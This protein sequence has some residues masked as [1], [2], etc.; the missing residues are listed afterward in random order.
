MAMQSPA[1]QANAQP[2]IVAGTLDTKTQIRA[3]FR[4]FARRT[5][6]LAGM[7]D[8]EIDEA[9][10]HHIEM[11]ENALEQG[12]TLEEAIESASS[13]FQHTIKDGHLKSVAPSTVV[14]TAILTNLTRAHYQDNTYTT[15]EGDLRYDPYEALVQRTAYENMIKIA[16]A[17]LPDS[18]PDRAISK[19]AYDDLL[20]RGI[21]KEFLDRKLG[22][23]QVNVKPAEPV[24]GAGLVS[25]GMVM[26]VVK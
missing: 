2:G 19:A 18:G 22:E 24:P 8:E 15:P 13:D 7:T 25:T 26:S 21:P 6:S 11:V 14:D 3:A 5:P 16:T 4:E 9:A 20:A 17:N 12:E 23:S 10:R 1:P